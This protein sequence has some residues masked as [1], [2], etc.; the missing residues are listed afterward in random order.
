MTPEQI[1]AFVLALTAAVPAEPLFPVIAAGGADPRYPVQA[2]ACPGK[3][4]P[5]EVE[6]L[7][8]A[9]GTVSVPEHHDRP[10]GRRI[11]L[12]FIVLKSHSQAPVA[13]PVVYL[14]GGPGGGVVQDPI[15]VT[16]FLN[17]IRDRRHIVAFD[18]RG[19]KTSAGDETRCFAAV[20][21]P[22]LMEPALTGDGDMAELGLRGLRACLDEIAANGAD[23]SAVNTLQNAYDV[24]ALTQALG[25]SD[26][27]IFGTSYGTKLGL[28]VM[29]SAPEGLRSVVLDSVWPVQ[30]PFY[31]LMGL[32]IAESIR[33]VFDLC[34]EDRR[35]AEAYP[36][37]EAR[38]W[39]LWAKLDA[40]PLRAPEAVVSG[41]DM[42]M[43]L[44]QR[45]TFGNRGMTGYVPRMIADLEAG[46]ARLYADLVAH[47]VGGTAKPEEAALAGLAG[48]AGLDPDMRALAEAALRLAAVDRLNAE[49]VQGALMRLEA[50]R[51]AGGVVP[52][53]DAFEAALLAAAKGLPNQPARMQFAA[54][55]LRL[56]LV[57]PRAQALRALLGRHFRGASLAALDG[58]VGLMDQ[59]QVAAVFG[60]IGP[61]NSAIED[62][63]IGQFQLQMFACQED[64]EIS[65]PQT[66]PKAS[67]VLRESFGW[68]EKMT[69]ELEDGMKAGFF[70]PCEEFDRHPRPGMNDPV[71]ADVPTLV[72]QGALDTQTAPS[73]GALTVST[74]PRGQLAFLPEAGHGTFL[75]SE[76]SRDIAAAF[77]DAPG[78]VV[79]MSC[80]ASLVPGFQLPEGSWSKQA[81]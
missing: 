79:D 73:W 2:I 69:A 57:E 35:C 12:S 71:T 33:S 76:C 49:T 15:L 45:N 41:R 75:F 34:A 70:R 44:I 25:Y 78:A 77:L 11:A 50:G 64:M 65:G 1:A 39:A 59:A 28:E 55:Y 81:M 62:V 47:R 8:A 56:R 31:D 14:H 4:A 53:V 48:Q 68:P 20:A 9:C 72:L 42:T 24:R 43:L 51:A 13:D 27:N 58:L 61:D 3:L 38:F 80:T 60:R 6:G 16:R 67:A 32:P 54:D 36:D 17:E 26:Y 46:D 7:T 18:Q 52:S 63:L 30:V 21:D 23:I 40:A 22:A 10:D 66:I 29:R 37:L 74:L 5:Y 19:V